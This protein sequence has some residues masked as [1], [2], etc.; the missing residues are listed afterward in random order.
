MRNI[1]N[2]TLTILLAAVA[3]LV[4]SGCNRGPKEKGIEGMAGMVPSHVLSF[5]ALD[6]RGTKNWNDFREGYKQHGDHPELKAQ[7][8]VL[9]G[10][11]GCKTEDLVAG[12][13]PAGWV[14]VLDAGG[15]GEF[16][17]ASAVGAFVVRDKTRAQACVKDLA[18]Q[19]E[20]KVSQLGELTIETYPNH[21]SACF[22]GGFV[23]LATNEAGLKS[24]IEHSGEK[25][26]QKAEFQEARGRIEDGKSDLFGFMPV[27]ELIGF[28]AQTK[29]DLDNLGY[30]ASG[31]NSDLSKKVQ[32][33]MSVRD[34]DSPLGQ[35]LLKSPEN[36]GNL[37]KVVP[38]DW[39]FYMMN[40]LGYQLRVG[41]EICRKSPEG[42][43]VLD[44]MSVALSNM[45]TS[46]EELDRTFT[47]EMALSLDL[48]DY[49]SGI[50]QAPP[51]GTL[52]F[53]LKDSKLF[54]QVW[55]K[56][57]KAGGITP[58]TQTRD[59]VRIDSFKGLPNLKLLQVEKPH[60]TVMLVFGATPAEVVAEV[61]GIP[62]G[63]SLGDLP[64][65]K[66]R[67]NPSNFFTLYYQLQKTMEQLGATG[68]LSLAPETQ[69][70][71]SAIEHNKDK[72]WMWNGQ[73][74]LRVD[75]GGLM[76][77]GDNMTILM[78]GVMT[79]AFIYG[80]LEGV[81]ALPADAE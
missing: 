38:Q 59:G 69:G 50:P 47:G 73:M 39:V 36:S 30:L 12:I 17:D 15:K 2:Y 62:E 28:V 27:G 35:A 32:V 57:C 71:Q 7:F 24:V 51:N 31:M 80:A 25:L 46:F 3:A 26:S 70:I 23:Y 65:V 41:A 37:A 42:Q 54:Q 76:A 67:I 64:A 75:K 72:G 66:S 22:H 29:A 16:S 63:K 1:R 21:F 43:E 40:H 8:E 78:S 13:E 61:N 52:A 56:M 68:L 60:P 18:D 55:A 11:L 10:Q 79:G 53:G 44:E 74:S 58:Q 20:P 34:S 4:F 49:F 81:G 33:Y 48:E 9:D 77:D 19:T 14:V 45:D 5:F 6:I